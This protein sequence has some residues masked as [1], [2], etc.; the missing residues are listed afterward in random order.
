MEERK[1][2][3]AKILEV[4]LFSLFYDN[5]FWFVNRNDQISKASIRRMVLYINA[6]RLY[7]QSQFCSAT[8]KQKQE[9]ATSLNHLF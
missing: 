6:V 3:K 2:W 1:I 8:H 4:F 7:I 5:R 9:V